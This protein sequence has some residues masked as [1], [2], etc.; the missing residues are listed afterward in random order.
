MIELTPQK[1]PELGSA[2][3]RSAHMAVSLSLLDQ[4][5]VPTP[6][7][8]P[9]DSMSG[10][11]RSRYCKRCN[12]SVHDLSAMTKSEATSFIA[13]NGSNA[14]VR[15]YR[16]PDGTVVTNDCQEISSGRRLRTF[17]R[18]AFILATWLGFGLVTGCYRTQGKPAEKNDV[19]QPGDQKPPEKNKV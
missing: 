13:A 10:N 5:A 1:W 16:R 19:V 11:D 18:L 15:F 3:L 17:R 12:Q 8:V 4:I 9:W 7:S 14:C 2:G 6:C